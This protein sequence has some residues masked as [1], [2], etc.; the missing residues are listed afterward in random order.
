MV[1]SGRD[2]G[3]H[4]KAREEMVVFANSSLAIYTSSVQK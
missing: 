2:I 1:G 3:T 4:I